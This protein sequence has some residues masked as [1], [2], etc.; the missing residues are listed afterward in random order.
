[1][2]DEAHPPSSDELIRVGERTVHVLDT[3]PADAETTVV[4]ESG[5][6]APLQTW[7]WVQEALGPEVRAL[8][9]ERAGTGWS[10]RVRGRRDIPSLSGELDA[11]L[12]GIG[13]RGRVVLV[14]HSFGGLIVR[15]FAGVRPDRVAGVV[16]VDALHP[17]E[18][19]VSANQRRAMAH[20]EQALRLSELRS[21]LRMGGKHVAT[22]FTGL[23]EAAARAAR[24][25]MWRTAMWRAAAAELIAWKNATPGEIAAR[26][27]P[28]D[29]ALGVVAS[30]ESVGSDLTQRSLRDD[31]LT[32]SNRAHSAV[33]TADSHVGVLLDREHSRAVVEMI[34]AVA[35][36]PE[37]E[38]GPVVH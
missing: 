23:P 38:G 12:A 24:A 37:R 18:L 13:V 33:V 34:D 22:Q 1:M 21:R 7:T 17:D 26:R 31:I 27:F 25:T 11:L 3:G 6:A 28:A 16:L 20:L 8:S 32:W 15:H 30:A 5:L 14:G 36:A 9:Y 35:P 19:R 29:V 10:S 2:N 4:F